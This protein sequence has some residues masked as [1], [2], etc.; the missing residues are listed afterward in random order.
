MLGCVFKNWVG[1]SRVI[2][3]PGKDAAQY[4]GYNHQE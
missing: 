1:G 4:D 3:Q 2:M